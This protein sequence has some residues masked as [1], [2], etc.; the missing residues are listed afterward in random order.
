MSKFSDA[1][2]L[3]D[4]HY[5]LGA[6]PMSTFVDLQDKYLAAVEAINDTQVQALDAGLML[7][8]L[9]GAPGSLVTIAAPKP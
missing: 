9:T 3:A 5:R 2:A 7:E 4:R 6:V 8:A 1:A